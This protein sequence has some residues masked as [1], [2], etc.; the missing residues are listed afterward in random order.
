MTKKRGGLNRGLGA[1]ISDKQKV[2]EILKPSDQISVIE[3]PLEEIEVNIKQPRMDFDEEALKELS[4]SIEEHGVLQPILLNKKEDGYIIIAGERRFRA[5]QLAGKSTIPAII[6]DLDEIDREK[7]SIIE[8]IQRVDLNPFE[9]A[10]AY[11]SIMDNYKITQEELAQTI[12]K[13]RPYISNTVRLLNLDDRVLELLRKGK[14]SSS[15]GR[16]LL[17]ISDKN[18]QYKKALEVIDKG[19][20]VK[21]LT[22]QRKKPKSKSQDKDIYIQ[23][24]ERSFMDRLGTKVTIDDNKKS[25]SIDYYDYEDLNRIIEIIVG[26]LCN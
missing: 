3:I 5:S 17:T 6:R 20:S 16:E 8:N 2:E 14:I 22:K 9:E 23:E 18:Q 7:I 4:K 21:G 25:I 26:E 15:I 19:I 1:F 11:R 10:M 13:S 12:G 24:V